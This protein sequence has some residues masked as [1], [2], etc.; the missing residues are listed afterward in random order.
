MTHSASVTGKSQEILSAPRRTSIKAGILWML[1]TTLLFVCQDSTSR[2]LLASYP[3]SEVAFAR[4]FVHTIL[5]T[6]FVA[7]RGPRLLLSR[8]PLLQMLRSSFL[9]SMTLFGMMALT[10]M[11]FLDYSAI[12]WVAPVLVTALSVALLGEKVGLGGWLS[13]LAGMAGVLVIVCQAGLNFS[14]LMVFPL[15][16]ALSNALYQITTRI[17][18]LSDPPLTTLFYSALVGAV[19]CAAFLPFVGIAPRPADL[20]LMVLLGSLGAASHFCIIQAFS[21]APANIV[22]P[23]GYTALLWATL[24]SVV[25]FAEIP[26]LPTMI[27]AGLIVAAGLSIFLRGRSA[28]SSFTHE[29]APAES[30][31]ERHPP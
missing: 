17:L 5:A 18:R 19:F 3:V 28:S 24:F 8:R 6:G 11:P 30:D 2:V 1:A 9:L 26:T 27:G 10:I 23:F 15:L 22:A 4:F 29:R 25:I 13:V 7:W 20:A 21:A 31:S 16:V 12:I 14:P